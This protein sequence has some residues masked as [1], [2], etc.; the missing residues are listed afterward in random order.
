MNPILAASFSA[1]SL[2]SFL[3]WVV[4]IALIWYVVQWVLGQVPLPDPVRVVIRV[5]LALILAVFLI[6]ALLA[7][8]GG[9][10]FIAWA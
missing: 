10:G 1:Q 8:A 9:H 2:V 4:V 3:V 7:V 5:I 6:N